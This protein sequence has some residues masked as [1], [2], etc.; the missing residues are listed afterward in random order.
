MKVLVVGSGARE[1]A[2]VWKCVQS[3]LV[4]RVYCA[5]GNGGTGGMARN[6]AIGAADVVRLVSFA[7]RERL[8]LIVLGPEA[9]VDAGVGDA[10]RDAGFP[11]F[12]PNRRAGRIESS[13][14]FAKALMRRAAIPTADFEVF[15]EPAPAKG[16]ARERQGRVAV[17]ADGLARGKGVIVCSD[18]E[19]SD[20]AIDAML[21]EQRFGRS[22]ATIVV[23][24]LLEGPELSVLAVTDG[25][26]VIPLAPARDYKRA[27]EGDTG[28]NTGGMGA[29][30]P[31]KGVDDAIVNEVV[32]CVMRP[33]VQELASSGDEFRGV[34]YAG[35]MLTKKGI[36]TLEFN[37]RFG[38]P[39]AQVVLPR[40]Q[41]DFVALALAAARGGL[42]AHPDL[43]WNQQACVGVVVASAHYPDDVAMKFGQRIHGLTEMPP[44]VFIFHAGTR[45][46]PGVGLVTD[47]GRVVTSV[48]FGDTVAQARE[49]ALTGARQVRFEGAFFRS[50]IAQEAE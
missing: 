23:E 22:G 48:A 3:D 40:L 36:Q 37:A 18:V 42:A 6:I 25:V 5:P 35:L 39:E 16:W 20:Q 33:A 24:E 8:G 38:D 49:T 31:P 12:G 29:Y 30:S 44:G 1:H 28:L 2:L 11:V 19:A 13:K 26:D 32:D 14:V 7:K 50:D 41:S 17:K 9:A 27:H 34:L 10:L 21:V 46:E 47:G 4:E 45:F 43:R 15:T